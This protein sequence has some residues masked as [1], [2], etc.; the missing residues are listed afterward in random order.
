MPTNFS[1]CCASGRRPIR[2]ELSSGEQIHITHPAGALV[3]E[4]DALVIVR[5]RDDRRASVEYVALDHVRR[6]AE[7]GDENNH[8]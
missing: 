3:T 2:L 6:V 1:M 7:V 8:H 5:R 4:H